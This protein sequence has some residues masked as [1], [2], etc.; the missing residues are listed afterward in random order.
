MSKQISLAFS[1]A[2]RPWNSIDAEQKITPLHYM[3]CES[4]DQSE[5][6]A[7]LNCPFSD[8]VGTMNKKCRTY[9]AHFNKRR[10]K[11]WMW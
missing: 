3:G 2:S 6:D 4:T 5:I 1:S 8:C 7:C 9:R 10:G 11:P